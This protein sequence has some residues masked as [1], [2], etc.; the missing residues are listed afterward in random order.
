MT[1]IDMVTWHAEGLKSYA[2]DRYSTGH[3]TPIRDDSQDIKTIIRQSF[4]GL[5]VIF[6]TTRYLDTGDLN[7]YVIPLDEDLSLN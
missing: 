6:E 1:D 7:D 4:D 3:V 2:V 5:G